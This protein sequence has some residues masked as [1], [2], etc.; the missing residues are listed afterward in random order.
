MNLIPGL[1]KNPSDGNNPKNLLKCYM[2]HPLGKRFPARALYTP[3][4]PLSRDIRQPSFSP[5][6]VYKMGKT[7]L[8]TAGFH[9]L[10]LYC[11]EP[12]V[13]TAVKRNPGDSFFY[14]L[15]KYPPAKP[16]VLHRR[17]KPWITSARVTSRWYGLPAAKDC[18]LP[19]VNGLFRSF[20][21]S[22][23]RPPGLLLTGAGC[24]L[25]S[26]YR[27]FLL[28]PHSILCTRTPYCDT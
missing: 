15:N 14:G 13:S 23:V 12:A 26:F 5:Y 28:Y 9:T 11:F 3:S 4:F 17:V 6:T 19:P 22:A 10:R 2:Y 1:E 18:Y 16:G 24:I 21:L 25:L 7:Q 20:P 27:F 8:R